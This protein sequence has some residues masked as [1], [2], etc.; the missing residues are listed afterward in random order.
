MNLKPYVRHLEE[1]RLRLIY[2][3]LFFAAAICIS[4]FFS[5]RIMAFIQFPLK[6]MQGGLVYFRP[7]DKFM[8]YFKAASFAAAGVSIPF[9]LVQ[10]GLFIY[11]ALKKDEKSY[12]YFFSVAAPVMFLAGCAFAYTVIIPA[13]VSFFI[14]FSPGD[15]IR[16]MWGIAEYMDMFLALVLA[17][18]IIFE[19]PLP[20]LAMVKV[21]LISSKA[22]SE[23]RGY[24]I[25]AIVVIAGVVTPTPDI[26][27]QLLVSAPLYLLYEAS[28]FLSKFIDRGRKK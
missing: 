9:V 8:A 17:T 10:M 16:A 3:L 11:P 24:V 22:L 15:N 12:F 1:L 25:I 7:Y 14:S 4:L 23:A 26:I 5:D 21:G 20:V 6:G 19:A 28:V 2:S 27:T 13:A 18:G